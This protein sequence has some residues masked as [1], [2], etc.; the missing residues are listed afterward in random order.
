MKRKVING[1]SQDDF[2]KKS[3][4]QRKT[5][6]FIHD[7]VKDNPGIKKAKAEDRKLKDELKAQGKEYHR[8][9]GEWY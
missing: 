2:I 6:K 7:S 4:K 8:E 1:N 9:T 3:L 5:R